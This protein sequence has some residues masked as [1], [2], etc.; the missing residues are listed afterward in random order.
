MS[1]QPGDGVA[2]DAVFVTT[3]WDD[4]HVLDHKLANLL[5]SYDLPGT[6]YVATRN[7][8]LRPRDR[9]GPYGTRSLA[10]RFEIGAHTRQHLR[11]PTL[12]LAA[13]RQEIVSG[14]AELEDAI[15]GEVRSFCYPGGSYLPAHV[16][17]V[18]DAGFTVA[19]TIK[20][21]STV[22]SPPLEMPTTVNAYNHLVDG[23]AVLRTYAYRL[24]PA[25]RAFWNWDLL[26]A[27]LFDQ[28]LA[29]GGVFHLWGHS[30]EVAARR[31]WDRLKRAFAHI[32]RR[33]GVSYV[34]NGELPNIIGDPVRLAP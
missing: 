18:R 27:E 25:F 6:F 28:V 24:R 2:P 9:V 19:R 26:A 3:S 8:E 13:A 15:G 32:S 30:C 12:S 4:G 16:N 20:R 5:E 33:R 1:N 23:S 31:D 29:T 34:K 7:V 11:L 21:Y 10:E 17:L 14:K 22:A